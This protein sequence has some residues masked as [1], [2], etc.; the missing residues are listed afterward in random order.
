MQSL[1][2]A[3][4][5]PAG[6]GK[7]TTARLVAEKLNLR[8]VDT[9]AMYRAVTLKAIERRIDLDN[10]D[11]L[12]KL[13]G[14]SSISFERDPKGEMKILLDGRDVTVEIRTPEVTRGVS[15]VSAHAAV[16]KALVREQ[17]GRAGEGGVVLDGR[18]IGSVVLPHADVKVFIV[19]SLETRAERRLAELKEKGIKSTPATVRQEIEKRDHYDSS[20][21][22][23]PLKCPVGAQ[24]V[25]TTK[26][27]IDEQVQ[28]VVTLAKEKA[29]ELAALAI[30]QK[31]RADVER[32][33]PH[34]RIGQL[35]LKALLK[36]LWG[37]RI[38]KKDR[39][40]YNENYIF[41]CNH[42]SFS[43]PPF[44]GSTLDREVHFLAKDA[45]FRN[46]VFGWLIRTY[47]AIPLKRL[48]FDREAMGTALNL[49]KSGKSILIF[50]EGTRVRGG[51]LGKPMS[52]IG[53][54]AL[55]SG[56]PVIP[57]FIQ[58]SNRLLDC[59]R[60]KLR[61]IVVHGK[62][63]RLTSKRFDSPVQAEEYR[64]YS[65]MIM[66]AIRA[67]QDEVGEKRREQGTQ[68]IHS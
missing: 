51:K 16:R 2:I 35:I 11:R 38:V 13:A 67:L 1:V 29:V 59:L 28:K 15:P 58:N 9:G 20:R 40:R 44:V 60:R 6:S 56:V 48:G 12:G 18:D 8:H 31:Q 26:L 42:L 65:E 5:G 55:H 47:N 23:S 10:G 57:L 68:G 14:D 66:E 61:L 54:L 36:C 4:D 21:E 46:R 27:T 30:H 39:N 32:I 50:P 37:I 64:S 41:A 3:V 19:A 25:D 17:R 49:L 7:S 33:R 24:V 52:G 53:Y 62:P 43:D 63:I 45:L 22:A 34:Y